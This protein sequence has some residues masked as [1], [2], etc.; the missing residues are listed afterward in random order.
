MSSS[1]QPI[2]STI[3]IEMKSEDVVE[4]KSAIYLPNGSF[5]FIINSDGKARFVGETYNLTATTL[6]KG[7]GEVAWETIL[8]QQLFLTR[9]LIMIYIGG[10]GGFI[11]LIIVIRRRQLLVAI[12]STL[13]NRLESLPE[14]FG[15]SKLKAKTGDDSIEKIDKGEL[16][17]ERK[18]YFFVEKE[19]VQKN[20]AHLMNRIYATEIYRFVCLSLMAG[21]P[22][23]AFALTDVELSPNSPI[24]LVIKPATQTALTLPFSNSTVP[25]GEWVINIGGSP[26][27]RYTTGIQVPVNVFIFGIAGGY[28]RYL[29]ETAEKHIQE[30]RKL[31]RIRELQL[32][33]KTVIEISEEIGALQASRVFYESLRDIALFFLSPLLAIAV[34]LVLTQGGTTSTATL[35]AVSFTIGLVTREVIDALIAFA[36]GI[37]SAIK[38]KEPRDRKVLSTSE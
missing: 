21:T 25:G 6:T 32:E 4:Y 34:W 27:N 15:V 18:Q 3:I 11:A 23:A 9:P 10:F 20:L 13:R 22:I 1:G 35:A 28:L 2:N 37:L 7:S 5:S 17:E 16:Q 31:G 30:R 8:I 26:S 38:Q 19:E 12:G 36:G 29:Y 33:S 14:I 24:G